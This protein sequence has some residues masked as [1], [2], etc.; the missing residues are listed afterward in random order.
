MSELFDD[1]P[2][3]TPPARSQG[4][5]SRALLITLG[6]VVAAIFAVTVFSSIYTDRLWYQS[7]GYGQVFS[8]MLWTR[9]VMFVVFGAVLGG[10]VALNVYLAYRFRPLFRPSSREQSNLDRYRDVVTPI[11]TWLVVGLALVVGAFAGASGLSHWKTFLLWRNAP[12]VSETDAYFDK[13]IGFYLF[14][15]PWYHF[16]VDFLMATLVLG[17]VAAVVTHYL[18]GG[19][20]LQVTHDRFSGAAQVQVS[21]LLGLFVLAKGVDY[22]LDRFD[23]VTEKNGLFTGM[24]YTAENAVLPARNILMVVAVICAVL[25]FV[26]VWR[27]TWQLPSVGLAL[28]ALSAILIGMI[29]PAV[30]QQFQVKPSEADRERDYIAEN[31]KATRDAYDID[32]PPEDTE[33]YSPTSAPPTDLAQFI[34]NTSSVP[35]SDPRLLSQAFENQ[36]QQRGYYSVPPVLDVDRYE[37]DGVQRAMV[38]GPR[39][40]NQSALPDDATNWSNLATVYTHGNG[41][42]AAYANQRDREDDPVAST[43][44]EGSSQ[45]QYAQGLNTE[46]DLT[47]SIGEYES[48][49]YYGEESPDYS[50]VGKASED[51]GDVELNLPV[52]GSDLGERTTFGGEGDASVGSTFNKLMFAIKFGEPN[53]LLSE[54]VNDNSKVLYVRNPT[55]RL[56]KVAPWLTV[57]SDP[58]PVIVPG[59]GDAEGRILWVLDGYTTTDRFPNAQRESFESMT[60]DALQSETG[61]LQT[62]PTDEINYMRNAVKATVDA[63]TGEVTMYAW[64]EDDPILQ[65]WRDAFPGSVQDKD[66]MPES[67]LNHVRYPEDLFKVQ[68]YQFA[69][70]HVT[71]AGDWYNNNDR[72]VV[73]SDPVDS[74]TFQ[75]P[76]R[77]FVDGAD[78]PESENWAL[79]S[80][81]LPFGRNNLASFVQVNSDGASED[82]G[83]MRVLR[84]SN[85][86]SDSESDQTPGPGQVANLFANDDGINNTLTDLQI[87][88]EVTFGNMLTFP[89]N[90]SMMYVQ[91][92]YA[93]NRNTANT[94]SFP[95]LRYVLVNYGNNERYVGFGTNLEQA[96]RSTFGGS[97]TPTTPPDDGGSGGG[98]PPAGEQTLQQLLDGALDEA[99]DNFAAAD[100]AQS[101][102]DFARYLTLVEAAGA[103]LD[104][105][106]GYR[107]DI[108]GGADPDQP[109]ANGA[110]GESSEDPSASP[111]QAPSQGA[112]QGSAAASTEPEA[113]AGQ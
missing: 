73:A 74:S 80:V 34:S 113:S 32:I 71:D 54:R 16:V 89:V 46:D 25:F 40:L 5:R 65:A 52:P 15:L 72:W 4:G 18:Y 90:G 64:D 7:A 29:F 1:D 10:A 79:T 109:P 110:G 98:Q 97:T 63:Y 48:R 33:P 105:A 13:S 38:L 27:R 57:D 41:V 20:R 96:I 61:A 43:G 42:I 94:A 58:Y 106:Q 2:R 78:G 28:L 103:A 75:P 26:N 84:L 31:I 112:S 62:V 82:Y 81:Y 11:R 68:R 23:L 14:D 77:L 88:T 95:T 37:V 107:D 100:E 30:V 66:E 60:E 22:Y 92:V 17:L 70:Y 35:T 59:E 83:Q 99:F 8:T 3:A 9:V 76:Y 111:S 56:E 53:F 87:N 36:Q 85:A 67:L 86:D 24:N 104:R 50:V 51:A 21:V 108:E 6:V 101:N 45:P 12:E 102:G 93:Q 69:R 91:P 19:I 39:E 44:S 55:E 47:E 49:I